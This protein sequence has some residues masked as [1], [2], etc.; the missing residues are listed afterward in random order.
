MNIGGYAI[1]ELSS[2]VRQPKGRRF[3]R[4]GRESR[5]RCRMR[6]VRLAPTAAV[7]LAPE[8]RHS[9]AHAVGHKPWRPE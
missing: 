1:S 6:W 5:A 3:G 7:E 8:R 2:A 9:R 4:H